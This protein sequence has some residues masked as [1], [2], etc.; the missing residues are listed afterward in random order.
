MTL[1]T[2]TMQTLNF[3]TERDLVVANL[4]SASL[5]AVISFFPDSP[6]R[7][8][9]G[10]PFILFFPGYVL[11]CALFPR[12]KDLDIIERL[13]L[14][15]G[16]SI[17]VTSLMGLALNYTSFGIRLYPVTFSIFSFI[18]LMSV[19]ATYRRRTVSPGDAFA[20]LASISIS[21]W[22]ERYRRILEEL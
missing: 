11:I 13:A 8:T 16:L 14:S 12:R 17:A 4:L 2:T 6:A 5:V 7:I 20:P 1:K 3:K 15:L 10:L 9:L 22:F 21:G 18:V 19:M